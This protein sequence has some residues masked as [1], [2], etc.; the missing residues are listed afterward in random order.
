MF[1]TNDC[2]ER[3]LKMT[4]FFS[5][6]FRSRAETQA[7]RAEVDGRFEDAARLYVEA[8]QRDEAFRVL[9][10]AGEGAESL[11]RRRDLFARALTIARTDEQRTAARASIAKITLAEY[12][13]RPAQT[14][15]DRIR[16]SECA[17]D[18]ERSGANREAAKAYKLLADQEGVERN[19]VQ[20]GDVEGFE[21]EVSTSHAEEKLRLRRRNAFES[22]EML[23]GAGDRE[24]ALNGLEA[25]VRDHSD[26]HEARTLSEERR[27]KLVGKGRVDA[28]VGADVQLS[29]VAAFP[30]TLGR[31]A[32]V[33]LRGAGVSREHCVVELREGEFTIRDNESRNGTLLRGIAVKGWVPLRDG[34]DISIGPDLT[35]S[36]SSTE[37]AT[38][39]TVE[40]GMDRGKQ[41]VFLRSQ[42]KTAVGT[43]RFRD[44]RAV[45]TPDGPVKLLGQK[46]VA[47][48][49]LAHGDRVDGASATLDIL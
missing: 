12:E 27:S 7:E 28:R 19:L 25:W 32:T 3:T 44:G 33:N 1:I 20:A 42:Y 16:L 14:D 45:L 43:L 11:A 41:L 5:R 23:W 38:I 39:L 48:I 22:F 8:G 29:I 21:R 24:G 4:G 49:T 47:P 30:C 40:R 15:E 6:L 26:D 46:V 18:L 9:V 36:V 34:D 35:M 31:E 13:A 17:Q 37:G 10:L 2:I